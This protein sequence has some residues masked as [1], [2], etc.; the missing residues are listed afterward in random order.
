M[1][2]AVT[3]G[4]RANILEAGSIGNNTKSVE[5]L[6]M[7]YKKMLEKTKMYDLG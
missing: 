7:S 5:L 2:D 1:K 6:Q 3:E 4:E